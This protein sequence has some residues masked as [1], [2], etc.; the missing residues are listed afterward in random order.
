M[1]RSLERQFALFLVPSVAYLALLI[2]WPV[3]YNFIMSFQDV[4]LGNLAQVWR[5][6]VGGA[7]YAAITGD[8]LFWKVI[9]N[10]AVFVGV[11]A[12]LQNGFGLALALFFNLGFPGAAYMRGLFLAGWILPPLVVGALWKWQFASEYG[13]V[14]WVLSSLGLTNSAIHWLA[15]PHVAL[16]AVTAANIWFGTPFAMILISTAVVAVPRELYEAARV[17]G[18]SVW[19][20]FRAITLPG[21]AGTLLAVFSLTIIYTMR[22]FDLIWAMTQGGPVNSSNVLPLW[23][24]QLSFYQFKFG[25]GAAAANLAFIVVFVIGLLYVRIAR[26]E[27]NA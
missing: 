1:G 4:Q 12:L 5:P 11:N 8:P 20:R 10:T 21:I 7:N 17:D 14:N 23:S 2:G 26:G 6:L 25:H 24:F 27:Q 3:V 9:T 13:V 16:G 18:A 22:A 15:D 19:L